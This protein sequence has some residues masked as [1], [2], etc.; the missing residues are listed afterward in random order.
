MNIS[1][2]SASTNATAGPSQNVQR[3]KKKTNEEIR[4][5]HLREAR[6]REIASDQLA[7]FN[8]RML[9]DRLVGSVPLQK[10]YEHI[11]FC[12]FDLIEACK[13]YDNYSDGTVTESNFQKVLLK[14][15]PSLSTQEANEL[16][17]VAPRLNSNL[18]YSSNEFK[19]QRQA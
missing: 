15:V 1:Q 17:F 3:E 19:Y 6:E 4:R 10:L 13:Q 8:M 7:Q 18:V 12:K 5:D 11:H 14:E 2:G 16:V 9:R